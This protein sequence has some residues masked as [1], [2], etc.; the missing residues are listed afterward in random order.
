MEILTSR[1]T[2][3]IFASHL[4]HQKSKI[5]FL[6]IFILMYPRISQ[7]HV[8]VLAKFICQ[9]ILSQTIALKN[10]CLEPEVPKDLIL[11]T[12]KRTKM[13]KSKLMN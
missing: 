13:N 2:S 8:M 4:S 11:M 10:R 1:K 7:S 9:A 12:K 3:R 6:L 5:K